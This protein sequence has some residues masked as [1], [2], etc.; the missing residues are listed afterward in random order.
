MENC[1][2]YKNQ[3]G[4]VFD[5]DVSDDLE[6][7]VFNTE[8]IL[9]QNTE[10]VFPNIKKIVIQEN[11]KD[12][13]IKNESFPNVR[14]VQSYSSYFRSSSMLIKKFKLY[15]EM[16]V[17]NILLNSF[18]LQENEVLDLNE[19]FRIQD[20]A[21]SGCKTTDAVNVNKLKTCDKE[22]FT[23]SRFE[24]E[25]FIFNGRVLNSTE[26]IK[27][28]SVNLQNITCIKDFCNLSSLQK[29]K[30]NT[31][32]ELNLLYSY[33]LH[34]RKKDSQDLISETIRSLDIPEFLISEVNMHLFDNCIQV[35]NINVTGKN[36]YSVDGIIYKNECLV[37][38]PRQKTGEVKIPYGV[39]KISGTFGFKNS[40][41]KS[42]VCPDT[43][44]EIG[45]YSFVSSDIEKMHL[46]KNLKAIRESAFSFCSHLKNIN[47]HET[48][49][50]F[51]GKKAFHQCTELKK[52]CL[53]E[54]IYFLGPS[55]LISCDEVEA[56]KL[57][58]ND[59][60]AFIDCDSSACMNDINCYTKLLYKNNVFRFPKEMTYSSWK[61]IDIETTSERNF[62]TLAK[63]TADRQ[64]MAIAIL[65][66][67]GDKD[68]ETYLKRTA[69]NISLRILYYSGEKDFI[70]FLNLVKPSIKT[71]QTI[72]THIKYSQYTTAKAYIL[73][74]I[75]TSKTP[76]NNYKL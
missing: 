14:I 48:N 8:K 73:D 38:C 15:S 10:K 50:N 43:M 61:S 31:S 20:F 59:L 7:V 6:E 11:V 28:T 47:L 75:N 41:V 16:K 27:S 54:T 39:T 46:N 58:S 74:K 21:L 32:R 55:S 65:K 9:M 19:I 63:H 12:I 44:H 72:F 3:D 35:E 76:N 57:S 70:D 24:K 49:I 64:N 17:Q 42:V 40:H 69:S 5:I 56:K 37:F 45:A 60:L 22:A 52:V 36:Y 71:I 4:N 13:Q 67:T 23:G 51:I 18:C 30:I 33:F 62:F 26:A 66:E 53:P 29:I 25:P 2:L 68:A 34:I 1:K